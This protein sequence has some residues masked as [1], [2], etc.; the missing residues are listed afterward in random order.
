[1]PT[2]QNTIQV[3]HPLQGAGLMQGNLLERRV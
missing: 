3:V 1:M 2:T